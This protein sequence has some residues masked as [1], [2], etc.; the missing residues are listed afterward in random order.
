[1]PRGAQHLEPPLEIPVRLCLGAVPR[2]GR[3][4]SCPRADSPLLG[5]MSISPDQNVSPESLII[6]FLLPRCQVQNSICL[7][8]IQMLAAHQAE[9]ALS[10]PCYLEVAPDECSDA[11]ELFLSFE[12][13]GRREEAHY[14]LEM[15]TL[16]KWRHVQQ[17]EAGDSPQGATCQQGGVIFI[18]RQT[19]LPWGQ[20]CHDRNPV[21]PKL[22]GTRGCPR[23]PTQPA[24]RG[25]VGSSATVTWLWAGKALWSQVPPWVRDNAG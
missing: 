17:L 15:N 16:P 18:C 8:R 10:S 13:R 19:G 6:P 14:C 1:M 4:Q 24:A 25:P 23:L 20:L 12:G 2:A 11:G 5:F 22:Q 3:A 7:L 9:G 21:N